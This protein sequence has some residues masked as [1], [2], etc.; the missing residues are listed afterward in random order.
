M[1]FV[2][3]QATG[4]V[5]NG[6]T[7]TNNLNDPTLTHIIVSEEVADRYIELT[8]RTAEYVTLSL[9]GGYC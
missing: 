2:L 3:T 4:I 6:G 1:L 8:R 7:L 9:R 5:E